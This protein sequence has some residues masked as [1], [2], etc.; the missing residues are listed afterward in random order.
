VGTRLGT[1]ADAPALDMAYKLVQYGELPCLKLSAGKE[2]LVGPKQVWRHR[3]ADGRF[4]RDRIAARDEAAPGAGWDPLLGPVMQ[5]GELLRRPSLAES[6]DLHRSEIAALPA[7]LLDLAKP[8][9]YPVERSATLT[10]RQRSAVA[11]VR[12]REGRSS[13]R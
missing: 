3:G 4:D 12:E 2:T 5:G 9:T 8:A 6:R 10:E 11:A 1:S 13:E 7:D